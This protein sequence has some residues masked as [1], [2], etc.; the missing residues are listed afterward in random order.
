MIPPKRGVQ[1]QP[2]RHGGPAVTIFDLVLQ[3][4]LERFERRLYWHGPA[5][6]EDVAALLP[7]IDILSWD[8]ERVNP[9]PVGRELT[10]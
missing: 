4:G 9:E 7:G 1:P 6:I 5:T 3:D 8:A 10:A 2:V